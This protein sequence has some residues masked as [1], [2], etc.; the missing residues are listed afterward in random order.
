MNAEQAW[1]MFELTGEILYYL[2]YRKLFREDHPGTDRMPD[3][4][5]TAR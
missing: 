5:E 1:L 4:P 2:Q 3:L